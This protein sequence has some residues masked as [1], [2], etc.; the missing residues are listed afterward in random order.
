LEGGAPLATARAAAILVH[1]RGSTA[2]NI[3]RL[4]DAIDPGDVAF[5]APQAASNTWYPY[6]FTA[7]LRMNEPYLGSALQRIDELVNQIEAGGVPSERILIAGFSQGACLSLEYVARTER[8]LGGVAALSGGLIGPP[9]VDRE[10]SPNAKAGLPVFI[11]CGDLDAHIGLDAVERSAA[12]FEAAGSEVDLRIYQGMPHM[13]VQDELDA[14]QALLT[15]IAHPAT[16]GND[17]VT[18]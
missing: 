13:I 9:D 4:K 7:P 1:G 3:L 16:P 10:P 17:S 18:A 14:V 11:G 5:F 8:R 15:T 12:F 6:P 2:L